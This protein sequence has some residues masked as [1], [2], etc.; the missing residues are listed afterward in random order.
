[1]DAREYLRRLHDAPKIDFRSLHGGGITC[2]SLA[3]RVGSF[4]LEEGANP[5]V[6]SVCPADECHGRLSPRAYGGRVKWRFHMVC[7]CDGE[8]WDPLVGVPVPLDGYCQ[9]AF[10]EK[11]PMKV[12]FTEEE[13]SEKARRLSYDMQP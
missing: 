5:Y 13:T 1:M 12:A 7:C 4:L 9:Q 3:L 11:L 2:P 8:A 6:M 10:G